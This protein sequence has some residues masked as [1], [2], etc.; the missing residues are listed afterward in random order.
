MNDSRALPPN[1]CAPP[2]VHSRSTSLSLAPFLLFHPPSGGWQIVASRNSR[3]PGTFSSDSGVL[4]F[5]VP[6]FPLFFVHLFAGGS[7]SNRWRPSSPPSRSFLFDLSFFSFFFAYSLVRSRTSLKEES[8][9]TENVEFRPTPEV[10]R[11]TNG[12]PGRPA[13]RSAAW[14]C[15]AIESGISYYGTFYTLDRSVERALPLSNEEKKR[16]LVTGSVFSAEIVYSSCWILKL[17]KWIIRLN[18]Y[19]TFCLCTVS[20]RAYFCLPVGN[21]SAEEIKN[22]GKMQKLPDVRSIA[23]SL[24][25]L[26]MSFFSRE[27]A[28]EDAI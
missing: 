13:G 15:R 3:S 16:R 6:L 9:V 27:A 22:T 7:S 25:N 23:D 26:V 11:Q 5:S 4:R 1:P 8:R 12:K 28:R 18:S 24:I 10:T 17:G 21:E 2:R 20:L 14:L 19:F